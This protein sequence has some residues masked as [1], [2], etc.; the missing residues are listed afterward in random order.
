[1][2][3]ATRSSGVE[4]APAGASVVVMGVVVVVPVGAA[5]TGAEVDAMGAWVGSG[6]DACVG[7]AVGDGTGAAV[8]GTTGARVGGAVGDGTGAAVGGTT[9]VWIG[10]AVAAMGGVVGRVGGIKGAG[11]EV[12]LGVGGG[13]SVPTQTL[14]VAVKAHWFE[15]QSPFSLQAEP[16]VLL[17]LHDRVSRPSQVLVGRQSKSEKQGSPTFPRSVVSKSSA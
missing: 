9:G 3:A 13:G 15:R 6:I 2:E 8:G 16:T 10:A 1:M 5:W 17:A 12:G 7:G 14:S 4:V 11:S